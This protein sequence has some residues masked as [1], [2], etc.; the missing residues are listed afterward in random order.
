MN[1]MQD[2]DSQVTI[3]QTGLNTEKGANKACRKCAS[4]LARGSC[5]RDL[6][7][8]WLAAVDLLWIYERKCE[9]VN[10]MKKC[11]KCKITSN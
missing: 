9:G 6:P 4:W 8:M 1:Y 3:T 5:K 11:K 10:Q 7:E 2:K